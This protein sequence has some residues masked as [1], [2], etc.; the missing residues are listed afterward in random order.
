MSTITQYPGASW[1]D[2]NT[3]Y[4]DCVQAS[5]QLADDYG[6][7]GPIPFFLIEGKYENEGASAACLRSQAYWSILEGGIGSFFG[8]NPIWSFGPG[9]QGALD[10]Q[11]GRSMGLVSDLF[12]SRAWATLVP[13]VSHSV[14][15]AGYGDLGTASYAPAARTQN[16]NTVIAYSP[17]QRPLTVNMAKVSGSQARAWWFDPSSGQATSIGSYPTTG[18]RSFTPPSSG[19]WVLVL[20]DSGLGLAAPGR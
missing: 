12:H 17:D 5:K 8:N 7:A 18:S 2:L 1:I 9:W 13:D 3:T 20:D 11:G 4:S 15:T 14:L 19:D 10:S 16:G 6:R